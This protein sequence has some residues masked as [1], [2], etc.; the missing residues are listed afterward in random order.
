[1]KLSLSDPTSSSTRRE[2]SC[3]EQ[4]SPVP[5]GLLSLA[6]TGQRPVPM[7]TP[8]PG[9]PCASNLTVHVAFCVWLF[10]LGMFSSLTHVV[11]CSS[12][13][14]HFVVNN[15]LLYGIATFCL[16]FHQLMGL[17]CPHFLAVMYNVAM[18]IGVQTFLW[19]DVFNLVGYIV[20]SGFVG[21][22]GNPTI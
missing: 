15:I 6:T 11:T 5:P 14:F 20:R 4:S 13:P 8:I 16:Y 2:V 1:M 18:N 21:S 10:P 17:G 19:I 7:A 9:I 22:Y 3:H 12:N